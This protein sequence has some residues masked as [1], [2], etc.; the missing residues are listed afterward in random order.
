MRCKGSNLLPVFLNLLFLMSFPSVKC[1]YRWHT[2]NNAST[3][4][5]GDPYSTNLNRV[6]TD[7]L[8][9]GSQ[10]SGFNTSWH[11]QSPNQVYG[12]LQCIG[13]ISAEQCSTCSREA[14]NSLYELC[15]NDIGGGVWLD[16]CFLRY[17]NSNFISKLDTGGAYLWNTNSVASNKMANFTSIT[18]SLLSNLSN[19]AYNPANKGLA[20]GSAPYSSSDT[21]YGLV[22]CWR[23]ISEN[24]CRT[25][26]F[27]GR[28]QLQQCCSSNQ[29]GRVLYGSCTVRYESYPFF[30]SASPP[31]E[32]PAPAT[33]TP[34]AAAQAPNNGVNGI[35][36]GV[37][38]KKSSKTLPLVLGLV[39]GIF[40]VCV[41][42]LIG[43]R[44]RVKAA[45]F[46]KP[47]TVATHNEERRGFSPESES[48]LLMQEQQFI[49][50]LE[51]LAEA[52]ENFHDKNKLGEGGFGAVYRGKTTDGRGI[53]VKK[54]S[55]RSAQGKREFMNEVK[56]VA[57]V[58]HRNLV[59]LLGCCAEGDE[60][61]LVYEHLPNKSLDT[62]LFDSE[63]R[64]DLDWQKRYNIILGI[65]RGLLYLHEDSQL[66]I[67]HRDIKANNILLDE[68]LNPKIADFGLAKLFPEDE[69]HVQ[70]RV[71]GTYGYMAPEYAM[72]GQLSAKADVYSFGVL[73][74]EIVSGR[75]N[76][77]IHFSQERQNLLEWAWRLYTGGDVLDMLDSTIRETF[78]QEQ[79]LRCIHVGL[80]CV[81]AKET[82]RPVMSNVVIMISSSSVTLP[83]PTKP[84]FIN[85]SGSPAPKSKSKSKSRSSSG[86]EEHE[87]GTTSQ[88]SGT[89]TSSTSAGIPS[90]NETS[91][92]QVDPR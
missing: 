14:N 8:R 81:Q 24:D 42:L 9:N 46:G 17:A 16:D 6:I 32:S 45:I 75:K 19:K 27:T 22:Q 2:C 90:V 74:L 66:R 20:L 30:G 88:A 35:P 44:K 51:E 29:G 25:C 55:A 57:N 70:T 72:R 71:A 84:A 73:L 54:L 67:I 91:V 78:L 50:S 65:A 10:S 39:G 87:K 60:R 41:V 40:L 11:G 86:F 59:K 38:K 52:T 7:L 3:Y 13:N 1:A 48:R 15:A 63:K 85:V 82:V 43:M 58:R 68:K 33:S 62:F 92:T 53:G 64:R 21:V 77:D 79:S 56:L 23:D 83:N 69:T 47:I 61:L 34:P 89:S 26:L 12:L 28:Q 80:L 4:T 31:E 5:D 36:Q 49:F 18:T 37:S 76:N